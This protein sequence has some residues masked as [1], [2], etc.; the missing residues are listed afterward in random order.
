MTSR[1][2]TQKSSNRQVA[3][4]GSVTPETVRTF[5]SP[6]IASSTTLIDLG[7]HAS[8]PQRF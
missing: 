1:R 7:F 8:G 5:A 4:Y 3:E 6:L 2:H